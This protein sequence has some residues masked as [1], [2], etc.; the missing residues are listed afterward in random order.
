MPKTRDENAERKHYQFRYITV[1]IKLPD[2]SQFYTCAN[3]GSTLNNV[4]LNKC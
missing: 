3:I 1:Q 4:M 2:S